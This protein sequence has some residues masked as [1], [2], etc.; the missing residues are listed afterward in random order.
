MAQVQSAPD[1]R[2]I[3]QLVRRTRAL[4]RS[5]WLIAGVALTLGLATG[6]LVVVTGLD[7]LWPLAPGLRLTGLLLIVL[8]TAWVFVMGVL[9][10]MCRRLTP[11]GVARRIESHLP[12]IHNRLVSCIDLSSAG[13][14]GRPSAAFYRRLV[15]EAIDRSAGF[16]PRQVVDFGSLRRS[17]LF[18][19]AGLT[20]LG[21]VMLLFSDRLPTA[22]A[23]ITYPFADI[24]PASGVDYTVAPGDARVL[25][26]EDILF[27]AQVTRGEPKSLRLEMRSE[28]GDKTI[29]RDL[30]SLNDGRWT[31]TIRGLDAGFENAFT[32]RVHGG[33]TW[34]K[35]YRIAVVDRP[36]IALVRTVLHYPDYM[37]LEARPSPA[38]T[39]D[40]AGPTDSQVEVIVESE[41][42]VAQGAIQLCQWRTSGK[43]RELVVTASVPMH[44]AG[45]NLWSGRFPLRGD[46]LYRVE[47]RN[48]L[49]YPNKTMHEAKYHAL[50]DLPPQVTLERPGADVVLST[51]E[52]IPLLV[53]VADDYGLDR[54]VLTYQRNGTGA[55]TEMPL[56][57]YSRPVRTDRVAGSF[58]LA[59]L[60]L[61]VGEGVRYRIEAYDRKGQVARTPDFSIRIANDPNAADRELTNLDKGTDTFQEKLS[62]LIIHQAR[63][64]TSVDTLQAKYAKL[65]K[66]IQEARAKTEAEADP[67]AP[68]KNA[69][70]QPVRLDSADSKALE[71]LR[72][73]LAQLAGKENQ[74]VQLGQQVKAD[75][76][77]LADQARKSKLLPADMAREMAALQQAFQRLAMTPLQQLEL[78]MQQGAVAQHSPPDLQDLKQRSDRLQKDLEAM[79]SRMEA[80]A[81]ARQEMRDHLEAALAQLKNELLKLNAGLTARDLEDLRNALSALR[82]QLK[83]QAGRQQRLYQQTQ[84]APD[85]AL[86][87]KAQ[88]QAD[89]EKQ[90]ASLLDRVKKLQAARK[91]KR[92]RRPTFPKAP[93]TPED[94][95]RFVRPNEEDPDEPAADRNAQAHRTAATHAA[96]KDD[97]EEPTF[98]PALGG[99]KPKIDPRYAKKVRPLKHRPNG[100]PGDP[101]SLRADLENRQSEHLGHLNEA[102]QSLASD[103]QALQGL[104]DQLQHALTGQQSPHEGHGQDSPMDALSQLLQSAGM[105]EAMAMA[106]RMHQMG[107]MPSAGRPPMPG[108]FSPQGNL[109]GGTLDDPALEAELNGLPLDMRTAIL[110]L[111][112]RLREQLL[113]G[114]RER[115]PDGYRGFIDEYF[116]R[117]TET[118]SK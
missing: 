111:Q 52:R 78:D 71:E 104:L 26:D 35:A 118:K 53:H 110:H 19:I 3:Y 62:R 58:D 49:N 12:G 90:L 56:K 18:A 25:R 42:N 70:P 77:H 108:Q 113:Q 1:V 72:K 10:P 68:Q 61:K 101:E 13:Q 82:A 30:D 109:Q 11:G 98:M 112:P 17:A 92:M 37:A 81:K 4:L 83:Q 107:G 16:R 97:E 47:L 115:G 80:L 8:P 2:P 95:D 9:R 24:P 21:L 86:S 36:V 100:K 105:R 5:S 38:G 44:E 45:P 106:A 69:A 117:L 33:G 32:Y 7:L 87:A 48:E 34:S 46:G 57:K 114:M 91:P 20:A 66:T 84:A 88:S 31:A 85:K 59:A 22:I 89:L 63:V 76:D 15:R 23:R 39:L 54:V 65:D 55:F 6:S 99:P 43:G 50:P 116:K 93:Y 94:D 102:D 60:K 75:L 73:E 103:E 40:V 27:T 74:N 51:P 96:D 79:K 64:H 14:G 28:A 29:W 41:G 67:S